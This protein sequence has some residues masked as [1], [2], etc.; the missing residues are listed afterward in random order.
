M[1]QQNTFAPPGWNWV[2]EY[3]ASGLPFAIT[4]SAGTSAPAKL[5]F[6]TV[7]R[8]VCI[9]NTG[10][11][12]LLVGFTANGVFSSS[13]R[14]TIPVSGSYR[15]EWR[16]KDMFF[17]GSGGTATYEVIAGLTVISRQHMPVLT[18]S[19][20]TGS[21]VTLDGDFLGYAPGLG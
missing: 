19:V 16:I 17:M 3:Q 21:A 8:T 14:F 7:T 20:L 4:G 10:A 12:P 9:R 2:P 18:A 6:P 13:F 15:E 1:A 5:E 11:N